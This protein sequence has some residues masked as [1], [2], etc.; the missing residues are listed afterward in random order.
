M[1]IEEIVHKAVAEGY[2]VQRFDEIDMDSSG[3]HNAYSVWP[4]P[5][6][7]A[8]F[9][10]PVCPFWCDRTYGNSKRF[11]RASP[12]A[13]P[14]HG[15]EKRVA[16][17]VSPH[18]AL[19]RL[20]V[21]LLPCAPT[22]LSLMVVLDRC[23]PWGQLWTPPVTLPHRRNGLRVPRRAVVCPCRRPSMCRPVHCQ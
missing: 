1:T 6:N 23:T 3:A 15:G 5:D 19:W 22:G 12:V 4:R 14:S 11:R 17:R 16:R 18:E 8:S 20:G 7:H 10:P 21:C 9:I 2:G 13:R